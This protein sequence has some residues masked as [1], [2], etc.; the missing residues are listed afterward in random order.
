MME[1]L[2]KMESKLVKCKYNEQNDTNEHY[3]KY[4]S[5]LRSINDT[6]K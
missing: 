6:I 2:V 5:K 4:Y 1:N 3:L